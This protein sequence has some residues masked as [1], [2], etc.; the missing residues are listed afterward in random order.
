MNVVEAARQTSSFVYGTGA[1]PQ[2]AAVTRLGFVQHDRALAI[3]TPLG[4]CW[5]A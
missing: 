2:A 3:N 4:W 1:L 5:A